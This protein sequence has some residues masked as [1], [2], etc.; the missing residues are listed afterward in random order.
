M[1]LVSSSVILFMSFSLLLLLSFMVNCS[2]A[3]SA[4]WRASHKF[5][6]EWQVINFLHSDDGGLFGVILWLVFIGLE[7]LVH[8]I[9][10]ELVE[11]EVHSATTRFLAGGMESLPL[12]NPD[13]H[14]KPLQN[15]IFA[16]A[17][18]LVSEEYRGL[19]WRL[20][21]GNN[22]HLHSCILIRRCKY[23]RWWG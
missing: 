7:A 13:G 14:E 9:A 20:F 2:T 22:T 21:W 23:L 19:R 8:C 6:S 11:I 15:W 3:E 18:R 10:A 12:L 17:I 16:L 1:S 4:L 5:L